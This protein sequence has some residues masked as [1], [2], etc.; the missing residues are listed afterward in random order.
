DSFTP[1]GT[2]LFA[3]FTDYRVAFNNISVADPLY[4]IPFLLCLIILMFYNRKRTQRTWWLRAGFYL[5]S[6]YMLF[7]IGNKIYIDSI[8]K[9]S[10]NKAGIKYSR[11]STQPTILNNLLWYGIAETDIDYKVGFYSLLDSKS[12]V[13]TILTIPKNH[14]LIDVNHPD[15]KT[16]RWFSNNYYNLVPRDSS[17]NVQYLDL[18]YPL[19]NPKD[20]NTSLFRF[21]LKKDAE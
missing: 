12:E 7:T 8:F 13:D 18:R 1:Y 17:K 15:I 2:Q 3:P 5:S 11:Y 16:L 9:K 19:L 21:E 10:F 6:A 4:T 14:N 20:I